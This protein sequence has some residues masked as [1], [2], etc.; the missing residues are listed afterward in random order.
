MT[1]LKCVLFAFAFLPLDAVLYVTVTKSHSDSYSYG[2]RID[3][4]H[5]PVYYSDRSEIDIGVVGA[6]DYFTYFD[7]NEGNDVQ[8][9]FTY[10]DVGSGVNLDG[11][12]PI[13]DIEPLYMAIP[14]TP[15]TPPLPPPTLPLPPPTPPTPTSPPQSQSLPA[16]PSSPEFFLPGSNTSLHGTKMCGND[17]CYPIPNVIALAGM[18]FCMCI[19]IARRR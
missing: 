16:P 14:P 4:R 15:P 2:E 3:F 5:Y 8:L 10:G 12:L 11:D 1:F 19:H 9:P 18:L 7:Y 6:V 13:D 17:G